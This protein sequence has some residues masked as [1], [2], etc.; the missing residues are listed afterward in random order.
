MSSKGGLYDS[1]PC[2]SITSSQ[3]FSA[4][5]VPLAVVIL[6]PRFQVCHALLTSGPLLLLLFL[7][8]NLPSLSPR[9][10]VVKLSTS[11]SLVCLHL[12]SPSTTCLKYFPFISYFLN[13]VF[14]LQTRSRML[15]Y[16]MYFIYYDILLLDYTFHCGYKFVS[17][18][19]TSLGARTVPIIQHIFK[20]FFE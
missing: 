8:G 17:L 10:P 12:S 15:I 11:A 19:I 5:S 18:I 7:P 20:T 4:F 9:C 1:L 2:D 3:L 6:C 13:L 14:C 16:F